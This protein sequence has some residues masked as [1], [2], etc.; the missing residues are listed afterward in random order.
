MNISQTSKPHIGRKIERIRILRGMKQDTLANLLSISQAAIS[1]MEQSQDISEDK[2]EQVA[3]ALGVT[4]EAIKNFNEDAPV[5]II[6][7][8]VNNHDQ[9]ALI[10]YNPTF[11]PI[12]KLVE[13]FEENKK[14][15]E[16]LLASE[17]EKNELLGA[18]LKKGN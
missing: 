6:A 7:N 13:I 18:Q 9:S 5:T 3:T 10:F 15:Y 17:R 8:T 2:L 1:K 14:L 11:N 12:D 4:S 16:R